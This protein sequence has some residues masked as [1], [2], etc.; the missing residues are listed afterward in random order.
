MVVYLY[1]TAPNK[2]YGYLKHQKSG[3][4]DIGAL[5]HN[6]STVVDPAQQ[7]EIFNEFFNSTFTRSTLILPPV[8]TLP[9]PASQLSKSLPTYLRH[10]VNLILRSTI[11]DFRE[12][13]T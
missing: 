8:N 9:T 3:Q 2:I 11:L 7:A 13:C 10:Y 12:M 5:V 4:W 6:S 1:H